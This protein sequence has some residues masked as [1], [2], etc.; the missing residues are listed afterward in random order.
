MLGE[1]SLWSSPRFS[2]VRMGS[3]L[4]SCLYGFVFV[5]LVFSNVF[6]VQT[7][8]DYKVEKIGKDG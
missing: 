5:G 8:R 4:L 1:D 2:L 7:E 6:G 3:F